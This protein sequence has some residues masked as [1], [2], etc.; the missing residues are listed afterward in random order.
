M[1][2][3][4]CNLWCDYWGDE[5]QASNRNGKGSTASSHWINLN[6]QKEELIDVMSL[7]DALYSVLFHDLDTF[8]TQNA[9]THSIA[10]L[11]MSKPFLLSAHS[12]LSACF[13]LST[14]F[15]AVHSYKCMCLTT[16]VYSILCVVYSPFLKMHC[17]ILADHGAYGHATLY[18]LISKYWN[19]Q[20]KNFY[21]ALS[22]TG[23]VES[24][25]V[26]ADCVG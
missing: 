7:N 2:V 6:Q 10:L 18:R 15:L 11:S 5:V 1:N 21:A 12:L 20:Q 13:L 26:S 9:R 24:L 4:M 14:K 3:S 25:I 19:A 23:S 16:S 22:N 8:N 17:K